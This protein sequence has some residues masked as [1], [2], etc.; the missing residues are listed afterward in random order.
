[1]HKPLI[2]EVDGCC[3]YLL[4]SNVHGV[5]CLSVFSYLLFC[6][7]LVA[8]VPQSKKPPPF[9]VVH[10]ASVAVEHH[11]HARATSNSA[12]GGSSIIHVKAEVICGFSS[13]TEDALS[14]MLEESTYD[15]SCWW[16]LHGAEFWKKAADCRDGYGWVCCVSPFFISTTW[17]LLFPEIHFLC[18]PPCYAVMLKKF[19]HEMLNNLFLFIINYVSLQSNSAHLFMI[20]IRYFSSCRIKLHSFSLPVSSFRI[21]VLFLKTLY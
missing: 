1:M 20:L 13:C 8:G 17:L 9:S 7:I 6:Y 19:F 21:I 15:Y 11:A 14:V 16:N 5:N 4:Q 12:Y 10:L 18:F 3:R 2:F